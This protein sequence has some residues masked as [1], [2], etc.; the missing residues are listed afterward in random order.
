MLI[1]M[2]LKANFEGPNILS[3]P[4]IVRKGVPKA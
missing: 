2:S 1:E 3:S 4:E